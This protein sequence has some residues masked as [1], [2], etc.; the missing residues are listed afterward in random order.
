MMQM[1]QLKEHSRGSHLKGANSAANCLHA[2]NTAACTEMV[3][4][5]VLYQV[6]LHDSTN[7]RP[8]G[9][10]GKTNNAYVSYRSRC[11]GA[12]ASGDAG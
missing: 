8:E 2:A 11:G 6:G 3:F 9:A 5:P 7:E 12:Y 10:F 1:G 4:A